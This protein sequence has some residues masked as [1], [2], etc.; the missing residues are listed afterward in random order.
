[1][2][3]AIIGYISCRLRL[4]PAV[5]IFVSDFDKSSNYTYQLFVFSNELR[6]LLCQYTSNKYMPL[7]RNKLLYTVFQMYKISTGL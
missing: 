1:M 5:D 4:D 2:F 6:G 7:G 3:P